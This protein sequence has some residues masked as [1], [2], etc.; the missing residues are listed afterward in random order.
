MTWNA[1]KVEAELERYESVL[2][3]F[4]IQDPLRW[5]RARV[6]EETDWASSQPWWERRIA[7]WRMMLLDQ[8]P[9]GWTQWLDLGH[10]ALASCGER[11]QTGG[12]QAREAW[13]RHVRE[14]KPDLLRICDDS[15]LRAYLFIT[16]GQCLYAQ[17]GSFLPERAQALLE[18]RVHELSLPPQAGGGDYDWVQTTNPACWFI[19]YLA[20]AWYHERDPKWVEEFQNE[21]VAMVL[22]DS[23][24]LVGFSDVASRLTLI[25]PTYWLMK[26]SPAMS[27]AFHGICSRWLWAHARQLHLV[28]GE[29]YKDNTLHHA[30]LAEWLAIALFPEF[31]GSPDREEQL[32]L[33][34]LAGWR[35]ELLSDNCHEQRSLAY[36]TNFIRRAASLL[37][38]ARALE[39][40]D[41]VPAEFRDLVADT[42]DVFVQTSTPSRATPGV[43]DDVTVSWDYRPLLRLAADLFDRD[44]WCYL[45]T[46]GSQGT[47]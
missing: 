37:G 10:P 38:V 30:G 28:G 3:H 14:A 36:H 34:Y 39:I 41:R 40:E 1:E 20:A 25:L 11:L 13:A 35:R 26:D 15:A 5:A 17:D 21:I 23:Y 19:R 12:Q 16:Q 29:A 43:N 22:G 9:D 47:P 24:E 31:R 6:A 2:G 27:D 4:G 44:D 7:H 42:V 8:E 32:W 18:G 46:D 33:K 45:A